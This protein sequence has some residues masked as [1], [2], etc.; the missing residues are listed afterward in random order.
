MPRSVIPE[1]AERLHNP[2]L[3]NTCSGLPVV[4]WLRALTYEAFGAFLVCF[5]ADLVADI[6]GCKC[7]VYLVGG[8]EVHILVFLPEECQRR[9]QLQRISSFSCRH[10]LQR[11]PIQ[12]QAYISAFTTLLFNTTTAVIFR[13]LSA[14][15]YTRVVTCVLNIMRLVVFLSCTKPSILQ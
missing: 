4:A 12:V 15:E 11:K 10:D 7:F 6:L 1:A 3:G 9:F 14:V 8:C 2:T 13:P 5:Q